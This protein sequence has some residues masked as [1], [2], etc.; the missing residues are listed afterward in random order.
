MKLFRDPCRKALLN[1]SS[2]RVCVAFAQVSRKGT[3]S[4][5]CRNLSFLFRLPVLATRCGAGFLF[6]H[7]SLNASLPHSILT[8]PQMVLSQQKLNMYY[9]TLMDLKCSFEN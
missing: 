4:M 5:L 1:Q 2:H 3:V 8:S 7:S 6:C 9:M